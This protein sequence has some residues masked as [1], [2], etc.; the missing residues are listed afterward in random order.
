MPTSPFCA[1]A[2]AIVLS[3]VLLGPYLHIHSAALDVPVP[4]EALLDEA[5]RRAVYHANRAAAYLERVAEL[6]ASHRQQQSQNV[7]TGAVDTNSNNSSN[8]SS[9]R[10]WHEVGGILDGMQLSDRPD[11]I[12]KQ[13]EAAVL[14]CRAALDL[15]P[16]HVKAHYRSVKAGC[17]PR[18][19]EAGWWT[20]MQ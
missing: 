13:L 11:S 9:N 16:Q 3:A 19:D 15:V 12:S 18:I 20:A 4:A 14:D 5:P 7:V 17:Q 6:Q 10:C 2:A 8:G 1:P